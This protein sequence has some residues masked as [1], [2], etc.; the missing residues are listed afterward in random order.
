VVLTLSTPAIADLLLA[1]QQEDA[2]ATIDIRLD[3]RLTRSG[4][5]LRLVHAGS[6]PAQPPSASLV[7]LLVQAHRWWA[8]LRKGEVEIR[9]LA[10]REGVTG[11]YLTRVLRLAFLSPALTQAILAGRQPAGLDVR[12]LTLGEKVDASWAAQIGR[13]A[14]CG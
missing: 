11:S 8:E 5:V 6:G 14:Q 2:P 7:G 4:R 1:R 12:A 9:T 3:A 10:S 13:Y